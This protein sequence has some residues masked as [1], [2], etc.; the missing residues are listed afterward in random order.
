MFTEPSGFVSELTYGR[1][2]G[3]HEVKS[4]G[5]IPARSEC[6]H[7]DTGDV[8]LLVE[9]E[10]GLH[11]DPGEVVLLGEVLEA[12]RPPLFGLPLLRLFQRGEHRRAAQQIQHDQH[13]QHQEPRVIIVHR[14]EAA[15][16][17]A[18]HYGGREDTEDPGRRILCILS[19]KG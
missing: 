11:I 8:R 7:A 16:S 13:R 14:A 9:P 12:L 2:N 17:P 15:A 5:K 18:S 1:H 6:I 19:D 10:K 3:P 4:A